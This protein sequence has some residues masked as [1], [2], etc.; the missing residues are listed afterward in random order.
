MSIDVLRTDVNDFFRL[1]SA[2][3]GRFQFPYCDLVSHVPVASELWD[4]SVNNVPTTDGCW[5]ASRDAPYQVRHLFLGNA[6]SDL[7]CFCNFHP[8]WLAPSCSIAFAALGLLPQ[9]FQVLQLIEKYPNAKIHSVFDADTTGR[10]ADCL[11][12]LWRVGRGA[13]FWLVSDMV[14]VNFNGTV[15][16]FAVEA[17]SLSR[18]EKVAGFR[19]GIRTHKPKGG[20][21]TFY[22]CFKGISKTST[23]NG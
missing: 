10:T 22:E 2:E 16:Q 17:F 3:S 1:S 14:H 11:L 13:G 5:Q 7:I 8:H 19:S 21:S 4:R 6:A 15:H 9:R 18:F 23:E 20:Y 12:A